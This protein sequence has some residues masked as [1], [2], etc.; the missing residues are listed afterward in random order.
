MSAPRRQKP[1]RDR[2]TLLLY[3]RCNMCTKIILFSVIPKGKT[4]PQNTVG[5]FF[6]V[7]RY[8]EG[9]Y[10]CNILHLNAQ[11]IRHKC[12]FGWAMRCTHLD[13]ENGK[14]RE[15]HPRPNATAFIYSFVGWIVAEF[16]QLIEKFLGWL[17]LVPFGNLHNL[18]SLRY[19][20]QGWLFV[21]NLALSRGQISALAG[22]VLQFNIIGHI[23][24][25]NWFR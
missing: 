22:R 24:A 7:F 16:G 8:V 1:L 10:I 2:S 14:F 3:I 19:L 17:A 4:A 9:V 21:V 12:A 15:P 5:R 23:V 20:R 18:F 13:A 25:I 6:I 11:G